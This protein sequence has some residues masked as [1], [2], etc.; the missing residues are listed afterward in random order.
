MIKK[1]PIC[2]SFNIKKDNFHCGRQRY[3]RKDSLKKFQRKTLLRV[4]KETILPLKRK[5][6]QEF[7]RGIAPPQKKIIIRPVF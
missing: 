6:I 3:Q 4:H 1:C 7:L 5:I 2:K